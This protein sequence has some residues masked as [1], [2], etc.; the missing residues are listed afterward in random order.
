MI[1]TLLIL[2]STVCLAVQNV[3]YK[4][5]VSEQPVF[6]RF[7]MGG[8]VSPTVDHAVLLL[9]MRLL[10]MVLL[11][12]SVSPS[13]YPP[14][15]LELR[16]SLT[17]KA[18]AQSSQHLSNQLQMI[19]AGAAMFIALALLYVAISSL[20][21]GIAITI[22]FIHPAITVLLAWKLWGDR[23]APSRLVMMAVI[24]LGILLTAPN[25]TDTV[26]GNWQLGSIAG[27]L[28][29][30]SYAAY[31]IL[32][33]MCLYSSGDRPRLHPIPFS[34]L[35][36]GTALVLA[37][38]CLFWLTIQIA[39]HD[40]K[41]VWGMSLLSAM[42]AVAAYV[43]N[44]FGIRSIGAAQASLISAGTPIL[45]TVFAMIVLHEKLTLIQWLGII[46]VTIAVACLSV[47]T[48]SAQ[49]SVSR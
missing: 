2:I 24:L 28:A 3:V 43:L 46:A 1:G 16:R 10:L 20:P 41:M 18:P 19:G 42:M 12:I 27:I 33:Q 25:S 5:I 49:S 4:L 8:W 39:T 29:G 44:S 48:V 47:Q 22:F 23:P 13:L 40:W 30:F 32:G 11:L 17:V 37:S 7:L 35:T 31:N 15:L 38:L 6:G 21:T 26:S 9:Q 45:T 34:L 14:T 36:F